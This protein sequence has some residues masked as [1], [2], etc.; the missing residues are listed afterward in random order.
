M[1]V[2]LSASRASRPLLPGR[3]LVIISVRG[4]VDPRA[5]VRLEGIGQPKIQLPHRESNPLSSDLWHSASTNYV[6]ACPYFPRG[7]EEKHENFSQ[8]D[9]SPSWDLQLR[10]LDYET[11]VSPIHLQCSL[12]V[13]WFTSIQSADLLDNQS[14]SQFMYESQTER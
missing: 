7:T 1:A 3:V 5:I 13:T 9:R 11:G 6:T 14:T 4:W 8:D 2:R 10:P 12:A